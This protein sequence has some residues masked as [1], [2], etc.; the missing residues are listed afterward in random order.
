MFHIK[1]RETADLWRESLKISQNIFIF[2]LYFSLFFFFGKKNQFL[3][4]KFQIN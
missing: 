2:F 4:F 3:I 1:A